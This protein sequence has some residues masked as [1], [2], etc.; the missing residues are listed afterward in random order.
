[1]KY[2]KDKRYRKY[3]YIICAVI[4]AAALLGAA[5]N[6]FSS[7]APYTPENNV[8]SMNYE[9]SQEYVDGVGYKLDDYKKEEHE[10]QKEEHKRTIV[11]QPVRRPVVIPGRRY[12]GR[13]VNPQGQQKKPEQ[14]KPKKKPEKKE[15]EE[16]KPSEDPVIT[17]SIKNGEK[18]T[19]KTKKFTVTAASFDGDPIP[20][21]KIVVKMNGERLLEKGTDTYIGNV[22]DGKN[23]VVVTATDDKGRK[24]EI[25]RTFDGQTEAPPQVIGQL[26]ITITGKALGL[27]TIGAKRSVDIYDNEQLSDVMKRY[28]NAVGISADDIH[29]SHYEIGRIYK[30]GILKDIPEDKI[31]E[32][33]EEGISIPEDKNSLGLN[34]FGSGSGWMYSV[35]GSAP[36]KYMD[37]MDPVPGS[38]VELYYVL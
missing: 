1:M 18:V 25:T 27:G 33:E 38:S 23:T 12:T 13:R 26:T 32:L 22:V 4:L 35:D 24:A 20:A 19:G 21:S 15:E 8:S 37:Q 7:R 6:V 9:R 5:S 16:E 36:N 2:L 17:I 3:K 14:K 10:K 29:S 31:A 28:L 30:K 34:D 11:P